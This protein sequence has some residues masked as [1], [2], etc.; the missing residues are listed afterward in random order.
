MR[1]IGI[2]IYFLLTSLNLLLAQN[3]KFDYIFQEAVR[4]KFADR[5][6]EAYELFDYCLKLNPESGAA[7]YEMAEMNSFENNDTTAMRLL[8]KACSLYP[9]NYW[10]KDRLVGYYFRFRKNEEALKVVEDM[11]RNFP[12]KTDVLM[13][14]LELYGKNNDFDKMIEVLDK[15]ELKEGKN[16]MISMEKFNIYLRKND[17]KHAFAEMQKLAEEY[18]ND[19]R[20]KV[21]IADLYLDSKKPEQALKQ[22]K[23][24][25]AK[26]SNNVSLQLSMANFYH[27]QGD[28]SLYQKYLAKVVTNTNLDEPTRTKMLSGLV[29]ENLYSAQKESSSSVDSAQLMYLF[30]KVLEMPQQNTE[31]LE[32]KVRFMATSKASESEVKPYLYKILEV[33]PENGM[34]RQQLLAYAIAA[35][36]TMGIINV[37]KPAVEYGT[38]D[39]VLCYYLGIGYYELRESQ[40]AVDAF[41]E[42]LN[43]INE[44]END[45]K[46]ALRSNIYS[47][48]GDAYHDLGQ[49]EQCFMA[50]DSCLV[51]KPDDAMVL[52][53]YAYYLSLKKK[54]LVKAEAMSRKSNELEPDN[55][56]YLDTYAWVLFQMK[57]YEEAKVYIDKVQELLPPED[58]EAD[59]DVKGHIEQINKKVKK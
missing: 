17:E 5:C 59:P 58:I 50:Y 33:D 43:R 47:L 38:K 45:N 13:M 19:L 48:L 8:E 4:L 51:Y 2:L 54:N 3:A 16:E 14:L 42:A 40:L 53:N 36:D 32:L 21:V 39:P 56:T 23:E 9:N 11:A 1:R 57:R 31:I 46:N 22:Y 25:E 41:Q 20:Y 30:D 29:Y 26:D 28:D 52:N 7:L 37:C 35:N 24:V 15:I 6:D 49:E 34:A 10:Y 12:E 44:A 27:V 18:P 55:P